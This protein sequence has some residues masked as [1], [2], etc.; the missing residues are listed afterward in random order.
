MFCYIIFACI[1]VQILRYLSLP[2]KD[3]ISMVQ[4]DYTANS[5]QAKIF[6]F[7]GHLCR[8][9][10]TV[11]VDVDGGGDHCYHQFKLWTRG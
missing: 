7:L 9:I 2:N 8:M 3:H 10:F 4:Q 11:G 6:C 1:K 5:L